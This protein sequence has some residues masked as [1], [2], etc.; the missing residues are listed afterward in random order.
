MLSL[1]NNLW[2]GRVPSCLGRLNLVERLLIA[3]YYPSAYI[4][5]LFP[6]QAGSAHWDHSQLYSG[7]KGNVSTY[8]LDPSQVAN[9][10]DG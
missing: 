4:F 6:K 1:A 3:K 2:I 9:M 8:Q 7:L 5:K 10:I